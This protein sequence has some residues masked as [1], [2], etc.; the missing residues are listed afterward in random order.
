MPTTKAGDQ[1]INLPVNRQS[2]L[3]PEPHQGRLKDVATDSSIR[4]KEQTEMIEKHQ[5]LTEQPE[6]T[7]IDE[8]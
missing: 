5:G 3:D 4:N 7:G 6:K 8:E 1:A 2:A